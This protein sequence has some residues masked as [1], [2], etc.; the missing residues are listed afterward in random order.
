MVYLR[1]RCKLCRHAKG[2]I[3]IRKKGVKGAF[4]MPWHR[5]GQ[6][7]ACY[8]R[9]RN[10][11]VSSPTHSEIETCVYAIEELKKLKRLMFNSKKFNPKSRNPPKQALKTGAHD[12]TH[13]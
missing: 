6:R 3:C 2:A 10:A 9:A 7:Y 5:V 1:P 4:A 13:R 12:K 8:T 11:L